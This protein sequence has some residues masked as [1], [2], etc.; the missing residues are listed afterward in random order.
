MIWL[1]IYVL[2]LLFG[3]FSHSGEKGI[4][5][6]FVFGRK[7]GTGI[8]CFSLLASCIGGSAT[9]GMIG[10]AWEI[11]FPAFWWLGSGVAGL[12]ILGLVLAE[13]VRRSGAWTMPEIL[14]STLGNS[15]RKLSAL[16]IFLA[17]LAIM[18]AQFGALQVII[19]SLTGFS[20]SVSLFLG[21]IILFAYT[22]IGGQAAVIKSDVWQ[23]VIIVIMLAGLFI[24]CL[25]QEESRNAMLGMRWELVNQQFP[26]DRLIYFLLILGG[27]FAVGPMLF[28]RLLSAK[29]TT[30]AKYG[31]YW[32]ALGLLLLALLITLIGVGLRGFVFP[33]S[34]S[35]QEIFGTFTREFLPEWATVPVLLGMLSVVISSAD[36]CLLTVAT[37][38]AN[39]LIQ[40]P[41]IWLCRVFMTAVCLLAYGL[42][43]LDKGI[44]KLLLMANDIYVCGLVIPAFTGILVSGKLVLNRGCIICAMAGGGGFGF[45]AALFS[46]QW[47]SFVSL[48]IA[49]FFTFLALVMGNFRHKSRSI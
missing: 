5:K 25:N 41:S 10:L 42:A 33:Y 21:V 23:F 3:A 48:G 1:L 19:E 49:L 34:T 2:A 37:I 14:T 31:T 15:F 46:W 13:K 35:P 40:K 47:L 20:A 8:V 36:S 6:Y 26:P 45:C 7:A 29:N 18:A 22:C 4:E 12:L 39:D 16:L 28:G 9:I 43:L 30:T 11:G 24:F 27:S 38:C 44:L 32:A 17:Y